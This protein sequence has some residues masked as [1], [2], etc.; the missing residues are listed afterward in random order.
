MGPWMMHRWMYGYS[1]NFMIIALLVALVSGIVILASAI[2]L[3]TRTSERVTWGTLIL[4][5]SVISFLGMGGFFVGA[6][7]G[8][9]DGIL[10]LTSK[11]VKT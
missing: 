10:A 11:S 9:T 7:L 3:N 1:H 2:M 4:V 5:F 8:I 6:F